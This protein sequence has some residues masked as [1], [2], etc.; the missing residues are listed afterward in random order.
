[1][2]AKAKAEPRRAGDDKPITTYIT[3]RKAI[4]QG[5][6]RA[7]IVTARRGLPATILVS[8]ARHYRIT[9]KH[10]YHLAGVSTATADRKIRQKEKLAPEASDR[11]TRIAQIEAEAIEV[12]GDEA[13]AHRWLE[14]PNA[15]LGDEPPLSMVDTGHG[16][17]AV[18]RLLGAIRYG[19][20]A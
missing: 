12:L 18:R 8:L 9:L 7:G 15:A 16:T 20:A 19:G 4:A 1:M 14:T 2:T 17:E 6:T 3:L 5:G 13:T 11:L 10:A